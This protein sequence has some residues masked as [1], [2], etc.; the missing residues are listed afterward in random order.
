MTFVISVQNRG[1]KARMFMKTK[2]RVVEKSWGQFKRSG[3][4][5]TV[6]HSSTFNSR[7]LNLK[8]LRTIREC[9]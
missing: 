7:L 4:M 8:I 1:N 3:R 5:V 2:S 9:L 6:C